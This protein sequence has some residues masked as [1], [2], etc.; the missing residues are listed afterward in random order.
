[1]GLPLTHLTISHSKSSKECFLL[2]ISAQATPD[3]ICDAVVNDS[4]MHDGPYEGLI[5]VGQ[6]LI[7]INIIDNFA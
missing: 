1:M 2:T 4:W 6:K 7:W 5:A 3:N